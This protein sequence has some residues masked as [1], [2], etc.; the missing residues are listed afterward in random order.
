M[1]VLLSVGSISHRV[2]YAYGNVRMFECS[3]SFVKYLVSCANTTVY[4]MRLLPNRSSMGL[5]M[6]GSISHDEEV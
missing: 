1:R 5:V 6:H 4:M 3:V 2:V